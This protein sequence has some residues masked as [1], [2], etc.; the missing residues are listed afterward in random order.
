MAAGASARCVLV[1]QGHP[2]LSEGLRGWLQA[3]FDGVFMV[4]DRASLLEGV[5]RLQPALVV[6]DLALAEGRLAELLAHL[7]QQAPHSRTLLLSDYDDPRADAAALAAGAAAVVHKSALA[8][9]LSPA[10]DAV[11]AGRR[12]SPTEGSA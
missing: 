3:S 10:V 9:E 6:V 5:Q 11:L 2:R 1:A 4:A 8:H 7:Q 12:F